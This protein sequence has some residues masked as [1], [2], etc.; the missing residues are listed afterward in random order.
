MLMPWGITI[1]FVMLIA[2]LWG[3]CGKVTETLYM[4]RTGAA[5]LLALFIL[6]S[7]LPAF[8]IGDSVTLRPYVPLLSIG[9]GAWLAAS[10]R[11]TERIRTLI[12]TVIVWLAWC[13]AQLL[14]PPV[15][16]GFISEPNAVYGLIGGVIAFTAGFY[17]APGAASLLLGSAAAELTVGLLYFPTVEIGIYG[18]EDALMIGLA[19]QLLC[20]RAFAYKMWK[21]E[22]GGSLA[23]IKLYQRQSVFEI[24]ELSA[25]EAAQ[26]RRKQEDTQEEE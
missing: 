24:G 11:K 19:V 5:V 26:R 12:G 7:V 25:E 22:K 21:R 14:I 1:L 20:S 18:Y 8:H 9:T 17:S 6:G 16:H 13:A 23:R 4:R 2:V 3:V 15:A 10:A